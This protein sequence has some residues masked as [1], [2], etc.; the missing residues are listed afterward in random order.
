MWAACRV[1]LAASGSG[2]SQKVSKTLMAPK[3]GGATVG[4]VGPS[5]TRQTY[6]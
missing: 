5:E 4:T 3:Q 1:S 6:L 2:G